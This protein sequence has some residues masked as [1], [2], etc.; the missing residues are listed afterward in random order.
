MSVTKRY[1]IGGTALARCLPPRSENAAFVMDPI[2][3]GAGILMRCLPVSMVK[4]ITYGVLW[5]MKAKCLRFWPR[6]GRNREAA[7]EFLKRAMKRY[8]RPATIVTDRLQ[9]YWAAMKV[10]GNEGRQKIKRWLN[11]RARKA[12]ISPFEGGKGQWHGSEISR[13]L[14]KFA[15]VHA[16]I[17]NHCQ[18]TNLP[19]QPPSSYSNLFE[20]M[21]WRSFSQLA[22]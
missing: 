22:T 16:S 18:T 10:I 4:H 14:Q 2:R 12:H 1:D 19:S 15:P 20:P 7:L 3:C 9:S 8:G 6:N 11:N 13:T 5:I 17:H 21:R